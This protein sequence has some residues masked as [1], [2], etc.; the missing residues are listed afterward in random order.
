MSELNSKNTEYLTE[1]KIIKEEKM[2]KTGEI[3]SDRKPK[4]NIKKNIL[5]RN[6]IHTGFGH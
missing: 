6:N 2:I 3:N 1:E 4:I 5:R